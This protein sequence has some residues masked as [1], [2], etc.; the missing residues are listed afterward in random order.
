MKPVELPDGPLGFAGRVRLVSEVLSTYAILRVR[1]QPVAEAAARARRG[2]GSG[3]VDLREAR[4]LARLVAR[5]LRPLPADTRCVNRSL[6]LLRMLARRGAGAD[7]VIGVT[8][9]S[10]FGAHAWLEIDGQPLLPAE[11]AGFERLVSY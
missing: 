3:G 1:R 2:A 5:V 4:R 9:P 6:V 10:Q 8:A 7:L 11:D